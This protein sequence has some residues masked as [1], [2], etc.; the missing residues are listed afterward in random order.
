METL[1]SKLYILKK[2]ALS[3]PPKIFKN[4]NKNSIM[5]PT[6]IFFLVVMIIFFSPMNP[7]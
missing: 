2:H 4:I 5:T 6:R 7:R 3:S 1:S